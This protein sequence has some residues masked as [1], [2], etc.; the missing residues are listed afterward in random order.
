MKKSD[1]LSFDEVIN[2]FGEV[3]FW[4]S[5]SDKSQVQYTENIISVTGFSDSEINKLKDTWSS[6]ILKNDLEEYRRKLDAFEKDPEKDFINLDYRIARKEG[7]IVHLSERIKLIRGSDGKIVKRMGMVMHATDHLE[8]FEELK[9]K[10]EDLVLLNS[11]KDNFISILSHDLRA[12]FTSILGFSEIILN[13][14]KL[15]EK[16]KSEYILNV[17]EKISE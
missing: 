15:P 7:T 14:S 17:T 2:N 16:D 4:S 10:S 11:S 8:E 12:P 6:L 9:R 13:E 5:G 3:F 1:N